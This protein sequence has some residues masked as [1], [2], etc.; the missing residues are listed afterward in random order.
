MSK[1]YIAKCDHCEAR[2]EK[3]AGRPCPIGWFYLESRRQSD[4]SV[5]IVWACSESC[6]AALW[7]CGPGPL[8]IDE[9]ASQRAIE[10]RTKDPS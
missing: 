7:Q 1:R 3:P 6:C 10:R 4:R 5:Y 8:N 9:A 2:A